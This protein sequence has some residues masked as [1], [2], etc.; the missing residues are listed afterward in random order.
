M[1][2]NALRFVVIGTFCFEI[3]MVSNRK[4]ILAPLVVVAGITSTTW[5]ITLVPA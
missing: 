3:S 4:E 1:D 5:P 2:A